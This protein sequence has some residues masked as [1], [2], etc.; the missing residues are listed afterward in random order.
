MR[1]L[2]G[3]GIF[4][5]TRH[6]DLATRDEGNLLAV[7][8]QCKATHT[9]EV[10]LHQLF[11]RLVIDDF[12]IH[13]LRLAANALRVNLAHVAIAQQAVVGHTQKAHWMRLE[14][15]H[16]LHL[17]EVVGRCLIDIEATVVALAQ[18]HGLLVARQIPW[19]T[20]FTYVGG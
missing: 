4:V 3:G 10:L 9:F 15:G 6:E 14:M 2:L 13:L 8:A 16:R 5:D 18:E 19:V 7:V 20:V 17:F 12:D 1:D 11:L